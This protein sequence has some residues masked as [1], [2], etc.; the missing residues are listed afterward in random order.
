MRVAQQLLP[1]AITGISLR[2]RAPPI[3]PCSVFDTYPLHGNGS[4]KKQEHKQTGNDRD[5]E[6]IRITGVVKPLRL[7]YECL[8]LKIRMGGRVVDCARLESVCTE[9]YRGFESPPIR[10]SSTAEAFSGMPPGFSG[11]LY[12]EVRHHRAIRPLDFE[13]R[14]GYCPK[15]RAHKNVFARLE[16]RPE[17][18]CDHPRV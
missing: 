16:G 3:S 15:N 6:T 7:V 5:P 8:S 2:A 4:L 10:F 18:R 1:C 13:A 11:R 12:R 17:K 9:R 14:P